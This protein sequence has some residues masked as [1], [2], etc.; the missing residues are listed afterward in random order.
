M[1]YYKISRMESTTRDRIVYTVSIINVAGLKS[2]FLQFVSN[3]VIFFLWWFIDNNIIIIEVL[4]KHIPN[5]FIIQRVSIL[6][7]KYQQI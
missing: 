4:K 6:K 5:D 2:K 7:K 3:F 1:A